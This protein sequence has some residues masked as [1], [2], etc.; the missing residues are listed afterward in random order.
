WHRTYGLPV[1]VTNCSNNYGPAQF[2]EKL[3]PLMILNALSGKSLPVYGDGMNIRDWIY[4]EDY[5]AAIMRILKMGIPGETYC[6]G[7]RC[8]RANIDVVQ[9]ICALLNRIRPLSDGRHY[10]DNIAF[11]ADRPGHDRRYA[12]DNSKL[13]RE[14]EWAPTVTFEEGLERTVRW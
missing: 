1:L 5:C 4:V 13:A 7:G 10:E 12:I 2:P 6:V 14:L 3:I 9:T 11:V 8:E